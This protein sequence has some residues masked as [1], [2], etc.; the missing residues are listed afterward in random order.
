MKIRL[1]IIIISINMMAIIGTLV[2]GFAMLTFNFDRETDEDFLLLVEEYVESSN[3]EKLLI[4]NQ[5][6]YNPDKIVVTGGY[7]FSGDPGCGAVIDRNSQIHWFRVD[8]ISEPREMTVY[9]KNPQQ[10]IINHSSCFCN[11]QIKLAEI[12]TDELS[13]FTKEQEQTIGNR[14]QKYFETIPHE[15][16]YNQ[17]VVGKYNFDL[18]E[19]YTEI[20][21]AIITET[22][23]DKNIDDK[24]S[25]YKYFSTAMEDTKLWDFSLSVDSEKLCAISEEPTIFEYEKRDNIK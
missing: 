15:I 24:I 4:Q 1:L 11:A 22:Q 19:K 13:Y 5:V 8:S 10:C 12:T 16:P 21:G 7:A 6:D 9:S 17:F 18:D 25:I 20:C 23:S 2:F 14:I 3:I